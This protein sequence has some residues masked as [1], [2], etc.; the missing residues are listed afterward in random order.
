MSNYSRVYAVKDRD[1]HWYVIPY[2][3]KDEFYFLL[4]SNEESFEE[5][6]SSYRTGGNLNL[7]ELYGKE[8]LYS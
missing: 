5:I 6:F 3:M 2:K 7:V 4:E 1:G 8:L